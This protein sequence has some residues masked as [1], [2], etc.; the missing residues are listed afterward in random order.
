MAVVQE[1]SECDMANRSM[2]AERVIGILSKDVIILI[3]DDSHFHLSGSQQTE[4]SLLGREKS[5]VATSPASSHC[6]CD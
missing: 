2:V 4:L 6:I 1:L 5:T 3:T